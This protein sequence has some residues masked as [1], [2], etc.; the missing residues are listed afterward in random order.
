MEI[1]S[2]KY[3]YFEEL[4]KKEGKRYDLIL[5]NNESI[6][7]YSSYAPS[8]DLL[9]EVLANLSIQ[10]E[11]AILDIGCGRGKVLLI[12]SLFPFRK[13]GG[14][15]ISKPDFDICEVAIKNKENIFIYNQNIL[16]FELWGDY[17]LFYLYNPFSHSTFQK[18]L[19]KFPKQCTIIYKNI[20]DEI[21][22]M[23]VEKGFICGK[24][25]EGEDRPYF[26]FTR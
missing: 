1:K 18:I 17:N 26:I 2:K 10:K 15:E 6:S 20:P 22:T 5:K 9:I 24:I 12:C 3:I 16:D 7:D 8:C 11:D 14:V 21:K 23:L 19:Y 4:E 13:I 25:F